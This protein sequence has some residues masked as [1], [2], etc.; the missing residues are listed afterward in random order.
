MPK[1][2]LPAV[3]LPVAIN[4]FADITLALLILPPEPLPAIILPA[5]RLPVI[6]AVPV[7]FA[8]VPV[9]TTTLALPTAVKFILPLAVGMFTLL[10]PLLIDAPP[11]PD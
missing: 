2:A 9:M 5:L 10:L 8:P 11:P 4:V 7:I 3:I 1:S 6:F